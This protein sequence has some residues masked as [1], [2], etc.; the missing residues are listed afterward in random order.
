MI[1]LTARNIT[2]PRTATLDNFLIT[3]ASFIVYICKP[4]GRF[5]TLCLKCFILEALVLKHSYIFYDTR[6]WTNSG[7]DALCDRYRDLDI[8]QMGALDP[9]DQ[10]ANFDQLWAGAVLDPDVL[11]QWKKPAG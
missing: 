11:G 9:T 7:I 1:Q 4:D 6:G 5:S 2:P 10:P 8:L 3:S